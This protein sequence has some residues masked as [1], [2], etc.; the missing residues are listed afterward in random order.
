MT[1][2]GTC[3][4][5]ASQTGSPI[6]NAAADV[7]RTLTVHKASAVITVTGYTGVYDANAHG[8]SA[9]ATGLLGENLNGLVNPGASFTDVP[10]GS[11]Q[12]TFTGDT[13]YAASSGTA[14]IVITPAPLPVAAANASRPYGTPNPALTGTLSGVLGTDNI[15]AAYATSATFDSP[16]GAYAIV[17]SLADPAS[18]LSNYA[19]ASTNGTLT[20]GPATL[21]VAAANATRSYGVANPAFSGTLTGVLNGDNI[22]A[23]YS[24]TATVANSIGPYPIAPALIDPDGKLANYSVSTTGGTL[25]IAPAALSVT[26]G[27]AVRA[28]GAPNPSFT[29]TLSGVLDADNII[30]TYGTSATATSGVGTYAIVPVLSDPGGRL[31]NYSV[32]STNGTLSVGPAALAA[33]A[34]DKTREYLA[35]DPVFTGT[36]TGVVAG[37]AITASFAAS[38]VPVS[39]PGTYPIVVTLNDPGGRLGNYSVTTH[40]GVLTIVDTTP[41]LLTLP[42]NITTSESSPRAGRA[43]TYVAI[44][45]DLLDGVVGVS[46]A[47]ASGSTF[48]VG[49]TTVTCSAHDAHANSA[50]G[51]FSVTVTTDRRAPRITDPGRIVAEATGQAG[52]VVIYAASALDAHDGVVPAVCVPASGSTFTLGRTTVTCTATDASGNVATDDFPVTVRDTTDPEIVSIAPPSGFTLQPTGLPTP[53]TFTVDVQDIVD[54]HPSCLVTRVTS[55]VRDVDHDGVPDWSITLPLTVSLEAATPKHKDRN[56]VVT[57]KCT[58]ASGNSSKEKT[59][60]VVSHLP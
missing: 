44:A 9:T 4:I 31:G 24:T 30:A 57:I 12:W 34:V 15:T 6:Y 59:T 41:P 20:I 56:Y 55:N 22:S 53:V 21:T 17:P 2:A 10:G 26:A 1:A 13:N 46:C 48:A 43:V 33:S 28:Y 7:V 58:D 37:D 51:S 27:D 29:G 14:A 16:V 36:L 3:T 5:T 54:P 23:S 60:V 40:N 25:T 45:S 35:P 32:A 11:A 50:S 42:A 8:A 47:P 52:A 39:P 38:D 49:T 19:V 18:R